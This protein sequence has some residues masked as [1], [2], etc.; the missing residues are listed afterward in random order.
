MRH[1]AYRQCRTEEGQLARRAACPSDTFTL[2]GK[3]VGIVGLGAIGK[4]VAK[5]LKGFGCTILYSKR[6]AAFGRRGSGARREAC[7]DH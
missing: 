4:N 7:L 3:T 2:S 6:S 5:L 1:I